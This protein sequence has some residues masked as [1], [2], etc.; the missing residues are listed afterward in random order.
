MDKNIQTV[1]IVGLFIWIALYIT[2]ASATVIIIFILIALSITVSLYLGARERKKK[3]RRKNEADLHEMQRNQRQQYE[4]DQE[5]I[6]RNLVDI[7]NNSLSTFELMASQLHDAEIFLDSAEVDFKDGAFSPFWDLIQKATMC[8]GRFDDGVHATEKNLKHYPEIA[9]KLEST[10]PKF[11]ISNDSIRALK[12]VNSTTFR[13]KEIVRQ[14]QCNFQFAAIY[15]QRKTN[16]LLTL[17]FQNL[18]QAIDGIGARIT[19][20]IDELSHQ[21]LQLAVSQNESARRLYQG[22]ENL[23]ST[24]KEVA[25]ADAGRQQKALGIL[26]N[27]QRRRKP[28]RKLCIT[29][30]FVCLT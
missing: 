19:S 8:L 6:Y 24:I 25:A 15:E 20:S 26:D 23:H 30:A 22:V 18:A 16:Q 9:R 11:P 28:L 2:K 10:P 1:G 29:P 17:G 3:Q 7:C 27:I 14:A 13:L 12:V 21:I 4:R 5:G